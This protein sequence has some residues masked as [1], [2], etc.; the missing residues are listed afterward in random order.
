M[1]EFDRGEYNADDLPGP[2]DVLVKLAPGFAHVRRVPGQN[3]WIWYRF[4]DEHVDMVTLK[5]EPPVPED[6]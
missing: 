6:E 3:L 2:A 1:A 4:D 5:S